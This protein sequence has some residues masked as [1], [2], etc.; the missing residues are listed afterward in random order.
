MQELPMD[1]RLDVL[2][3]NGDNKYLQSNLRVLAKYVAYMHTNIVEPAIPTQQIRWG[4]FEQ[5][6]DKLEHNLELID[7]LLRIYDGGHFSASKESKY[8]FKLL[9]FLNLHRRKLPKQIIV[10][11]K[12]KETLIALRSN[13]RNILRRNPYQGY[14]EER[15]E[16]QR[17]KRCHGDLKSPHIWI[18]PYTFIS[19]S[20]PW[21]HV[22]V[23]DAI[24]FN[25]TYCNIDI[26]SDL[27][28]LILDIQ[29]RTKSTEITSQF[30]K[31]YL[32]LTSQEDEISQAVLAFYLI[33]KAIMWTAVSII[34]DDLPDL[35][36]AFLD[37]ANNR[38]VDIDTLEIPQI[39]SPNSPLLLKNFQFKRN[40]SG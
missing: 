1:R 21:M 32:R 33:E 15:I 13:L 4:S 28:M 30:V 26:L 39:T 22:R 16:Q 11:E 18:T 23:I 37:I 31:D 6:Q 10:T 25:P 5:L 7:H 35:G 17:I 20:K 34:Y 3:N 40:H 12:Q 8:L 19:D 2:L 9:H 29:A 38:M 36:L 24:D 14:F 27:A